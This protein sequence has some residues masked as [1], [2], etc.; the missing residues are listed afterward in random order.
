MSQTNIKPI[1]DNICNAI[2]DYYNL[3]QLIKKSWL[4]KK[5]ILVMD[6]AGY[7]IYDKN[8]ELQ[9]WIGIKDKYE[10]LM[11]IIFYGGVLYDNAEKNFKGPMEIFD[12]DEDMWIYSELNIIDIL[13]KKHL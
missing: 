13:Q 1:T 3:M 9:A 6:G 5:Y 12:F 4:N 7:N 11:F 8:D 10:C 2:N